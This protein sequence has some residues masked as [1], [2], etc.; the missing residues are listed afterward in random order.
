VIVGR[1]RFKREDVIKFVANKLGA[2][3]LNPSRD[4]DERVLEAA[5][6]QYLLQGDKPI[7]NEL[8]SRTVSS[9]PHPRTHSASWARCRGLTDGGVDRCTARPTVALSLART[10]RPLQPATAAP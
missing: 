6:D 9:S 5:N 8:L 3:H 10:A 7:F 4:D 1:R 2:A